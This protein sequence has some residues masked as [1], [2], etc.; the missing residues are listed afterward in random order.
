MRLSV[1]ASRF[2][3]MEMKTNLFHLLS[4][5]ELSLIEKSQVPLRLCKK[6]FTMNAENGFWVGLK[7][8]KAKLN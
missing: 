6:T 5:Y 4:K 2:A 1:I 7:R 3:L 8:R